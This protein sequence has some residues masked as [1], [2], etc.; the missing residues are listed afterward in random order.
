MIWYILTF[1]AGWYVREAVALHKIRV[2]VKTMQDVEET[3]IIDELKVNIEKHNDQFYL[4]RD[5][6]DQFI[7]QGATKADVI[8]VLKKRY[9]AQTVVVDPDN[10]KEVDFK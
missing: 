2:I 10:V 3:P 1:V 8:D 9:P 4:Y 5:S 6:D 7:A